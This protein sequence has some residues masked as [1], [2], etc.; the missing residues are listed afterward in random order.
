MASSPIKALL[1]HAHTKVDEATRRLGE[2]LAS[3]QACEVKLDMLMQYRKEYRERFMQAAQTGIG[4]DA[5]R[6]Y[7][8]FINK[9]DEAIGQQQKVVEH[10]R[11]MTANGQQ[12]WVHERNRMKAFDALSQ[13][14]IAQAQHIHNKQEQR[15]SDEHAIKLYR[16]TDE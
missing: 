9:L 13:R 7:S 15:Q 10:S 5:W 8:G 2:L 6:N 14:Q 4:P 1:E 11:N 16:K 12:Q 3:E